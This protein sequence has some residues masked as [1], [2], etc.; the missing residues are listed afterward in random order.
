MRLNITET[1]D[2]SP[3]RKKNSPIILF[4]LLIIL[5]LSGCKGRQDKSKENSQELMTVRTLGLAYLEEFKLEEAEK[6]FLKFIDLAPDE[7]FGYA[8]LG[9]TYLRL[10][11]YPEAE[12]HLLHAIEIDST[13]ADI[14]LIMA[15]VYKMSDKPEQAIDVLKKSLEFAPDHVKTLYELTE[16]YSAKTDQESMDQSR[17]YLELLISRAPGNLVPRLNLTDILIRT[18][19]FD[20]AVEQLEIIKQQFPE[21][22]KEAIDHYNNAISALRK[23]DREKAILQF[24]VFHNYIKV[25]PPYQAGMVDL[26]GPGGSLI[27][28]PLITFDRGALSTLPAD[29]S[30]LDVLKFTEVSASAGLNV[31]DLQANTTINKTT[32]Y[33]HIEASDYDMD[34]DID[35][36]AGCF[37]C[38]I[39]YKHFLFSNNSGRFTEISRASGLTHSGKET[40]AV[41]GDYDNDGYPDLYIIRD[42]GDILYRNNT[43]GGFEDVTRKA[44]IGSK[45]GGMS[46]L[47]LDADHDGDLDLFESGSEG[48]LLF[49]NNSDGSF[50]EKARDMKLSA[51]KSS[52]AAFG[53]FDDDGDLDLFVVG[54]NGTNVLYSNQRQGIF[55]DITSESGLDGNGG[56]GTVAVSDYNNDGFLD[57]FIGYSSGKNHIL[58]RNLGTG[59]FEKTAPTELLKLTDQVIIHDVAFLDFDNDGFSDLFIAGENPDKT[60]G[61]LFLFHNDGKG[62]FINTSSLLPAEPLSGNSIAVFDYNDDGDQDIAVARIGGGFLLLRND[63][64]NINHFVKI[65]LVGLRAGSA[66]NNHFGIGAKVEMRAGDLYQTMV[67][68]DPNIQFGIGNR[69]VADVIRITWTNGVPQNIFLPAADQALIEAQTLKGSCPFL[70]TW[71]GG[72]FEFVKDILWRSGLGMPLGIMGGTTAYAFADASDDYLKVPGESMKTVNGMYP[73]QV[74]SELWETIYLDKFQVVAVDHPASTDI[75]VEEQFSPPPFPG[76]KIFHVDKK[77]VPVTAVDSRG[78]DVLS[79]IKEKDDVY[80]SDFKVDKYQGVTEMKDLI[81]D[82]GNSM[83]SKNL[84]LFMNG[85]IFPT[86]ASINVAL[87]QSDSIKVF[88]PIVQVKNNKGDWQTIIEGLGFPMGKNKTVIADL[89]GKFL[90]TDHRIRIRTNM[91][92]YWDQIFFAEGNSQQQLVTKIMDPVSADLHYRGFSASYRKGGR[93]GPHWF[94]YSKVSKDQKWRDLQGDYTR[95]G[96]VLPLLKTS[97]NKYIISNAGDETTILF[98]SKNL[99]LLKTGW[100][101]DFLINSV[102]WVKDGD[103]NTAFGN[104]VKP[105][106]FHGMKS[107]PP[108]EKDIYPDNPDLQRYNQDYNTRKVT[109]AGYL[110]ALK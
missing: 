3:M 10:G 46:A 51:E 70:Y 105:L 90:T 2:S 98:D 93:Y 23:K 81:I 95:Y 56:Q 41:F 47:F 22:P 48:S 39:L 108:S 61:G 97:D 53:D 43:K 63:G 77:Y 89:K 49:R 68:S 38:F 30:I 9:L 101:R 71:D 72:K 8:N 84:I 79:L 110:N 5:V 73:V 40:A 99:P 14:R 29:E 107:Y 26:K 62:D 59:R 13:D 32:G 54:I 52:D 37:D 7:K 12:K 15:T 103:I 65:K 66:K 27:G 92:I 69:S 42:E 45:T 91:Q 100:K 109:S 24:T 74:T 25:T 50:I 60:K 19:E 34:G 64:G 20:K 17:N 18:N 11:K 6:E 58:Y 33:S 76:L 1:N 28:F 67:V 94:N 82:P 36:Y 102:G 44:A 4:M 106:P 57:I 78:N 55:S 75:F 80:I 85:W 16:M 104:T 86:D 88:P 87:S 83:D 31:I 96:D 35:I 21:F